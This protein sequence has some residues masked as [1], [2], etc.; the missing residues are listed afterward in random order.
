[1]ENTLITPAPVEEGNEGSRPLL[2]QK[3]VLHSPKINGQCHTKSTARSF[4]Q[5][6]LVQDGTL[7][8]TQVPQSGRQVGGME[9]A[10]HSKWQQPFV[11]DVDNAGSE[12]TKTPVDGLVGDSPKSASFDIYAEPAV[13]TA[14]QHAEK[15]QSNGAPGGNRMHTWASMGRS[16]SGL[17]PLER[18]GSPTIAADKWYPEEHNASR[19]THKNDRKR[20]KSRGKHYEMNKRPCIEL[21]VAGRFGEK[22]TRAMLRQ[23]RARAKAEDYQVYGPQ[24]LATAE[25][26]IGFLKDSMVLQSE[27]TSTKPVS[28]QCRNPSEPPR[29]G[30]VREPGETPSAPQK[31][32][33]VHG[34]RWKSR[35]SEYKTNK[36]PCRE[37][38]V[39]RHLHEISAGACRRPVRRRT[40][41]AKGQVYGLRAEATTEKMTAFLKRSRVPQSENNST[42]PVSQQCRNPSEPPRTG[43]VREPGET[44]SAPQKPYKVH[45][46]RWK[47]RISEYKTNKRPCRELPVLR[48]LHEISAGACR[49]P[50]RRRTDLAKGQVYGLRAEATTEKMTAFLKRSRVPQ[51]ENNSTAPVSQQCRNPSEPPRTGPV[52]KPFPSQEQYKG[53]GKRWKSRESDFKMNKRPCIEHP[54]A[55][56]SD[57]TSA[58]TCRRPIRRQTNLGKCRVY[59]LRAQA[60]VE[61]TT[62]FLSDSNVPRNDCNPT[63]PVSQ[64]C[65]AHTDLPR[66]GPNPEPVKTSNT[67]QNSPKTFSAVFNDLVTPTPPQ[68]PNAELMASTLSQRRP[69]CPQP[70][71]HRHAFSSTGG[72]TQHVGSRQGASGENQAPH[73]TNGGPGALPNR[74]A[75]KNVGNALEP[76]IKSTGA[77]EPT[78]PG[79]LQ[80]MRNYATHDFPDGG[81]DNARLQPSPQRALPKTSR[82]RARAI[83]QLRKTKNCPKKAD[84]AHWMNTFAFIVELN[85]EKVTRAYHR[86]KESIK[87]FL[88]R[89][90]RQQSKAGNFF[91]KSLRIV[92]LDPSR[93]G[94]TH[95]D[96]FFQ[97]EDTLVFQHTQHDEVNPT[98]LVRVINRAIQS[99]KKEM[100]SPVTAK[101]TY[102]L[103]SKK[104]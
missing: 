38:P 40:D 5:G 84:Y 15:A 83:A 42:E 98:R 4:P 59:G 66:T 101:H 51:S 52:Q 35:I 33:K 64:Q 2:Q 14:P 45:G 37:L 67:S 20:R 47:S 99:K 80:G 18:N 19:M 86:P 71:Q 23:R 30:P 85:G 32:Y 48:H 76:N 100:V 88:E 49:R 82:S 87:P 46:K 60:I 44:P 62:A 41:L 91:N 57:A 74:K 9:A 90:F 95:M 79:T 13:P 34:K 10:T 53:A 24:A 58:W 55:R 68:G 65:R 16:V 1:M 6:Q 93:N 73:L 7:R 29:T 22:P 39:L 78:P 56:P 12:C 3:E 96:R 31:P 72:S 27:N 70:G 89:H 28:Q 102:Y 63:E 17:A 11:E 26:M 104:R 103:R 69:E 61:E 75:L 8:Q 81:P 50:V 21:S 43:P 25:E 94:A 97:T 92:E 54:V 77:S 36:R